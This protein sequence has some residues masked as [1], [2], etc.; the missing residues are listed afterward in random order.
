MSGSVDVPVTGGLTY[1]D[2]HGLTEVVARLRRALRASIRSEYPWESLSMAQIEVLQSLAD[3]SPDRAGDLAARLRLAPSTVSGLLTQMIACG[4]VERGTDTHD[5]RV[6]VV[7]LS[8]AGRAQLAGWNAAHR[9]RIAAALTVLEPDEC[10]AIDGA[11]PAL[12]RLAELLTAA[13]AEA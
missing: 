7:A 12:M 1:G 3:H 10:V 5:R 8:E 4:L 6:S 9:R 11:L 13:P 2:A